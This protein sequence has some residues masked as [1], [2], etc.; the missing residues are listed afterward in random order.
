MTA[1]TAI[2]KP[3]LQARE[4]LEKNAYFLL[5]LLAGYA[6]IRSIVGAALRTFWFDELCTLAVAS[7]PNLRAV[8]DALASAVDAHPI[9]FYVAERAARGVTA[10][11]HIASR[12]PAILAFPCTLI[13]I[14]VY[15]KKRSGNLAALIASF[16]LL[17]T[18]LFEQ[19][20]R[21]A[22]AYSLVVACISLALVCYQRASAP[23]WRVL[24]ALSLMLAESFHHYSL[25]AFVPFGLA[26][27]V[28]F[29]R[30]HRFR[31]GVWL[32]IVLGPL[33][34]AFSWSLLLHVREHFGAHFFQHY[35][36]R[37]IAATYG[38]YFL[39]DSA[40][41]TA[42]VGLCFLA[43]IFLTLRQEREDWGETAK[44]RDLQL[45]EGTMV[46]GLLILPAIGWIMVTLMHAGM[47]DTYTISALLGVCLAVGMIVP[48]LRPLGVALFI[49]FLLLNVGFREFKFWES[50]RSL[51]LETPAPGLETFLRD[52]G[53]SDSQ[54]P[55]VVANGMIYVPFAYYV[56]DPLWHRLYY[57]T[58]EE[59]EIRYQ[60]AD[61][62]DRNVKLLNQYMPMQL[63]DFS[64]FAS[65][66]PVFLM[67]G[68]D[69]GYG[70]TWLA[71]YLS[72]EKYSVMA[73]GVD[74]TRRLFLVNMKKAA[75]GE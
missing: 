65:T 55:I 37:A 27:A 20:A 47:R 4:W 33:P 29:F 61:T 34:L 11:E 46:L 22:R 19:Y 40:Y 49:V 25:F 38:A 35:G 23:V 54:L 14:F 66:H 36:F 63:Q 42:I 69:P 18:V 7:R 48:Y 9:G 15:V 45:A 31:W 30:T 24:L 8:W 43:T 68:E 21:E 74:P 58:D 53:Y 67:Y 1:Q 39:T 13:C 51:H 17:S 41:G 50:A 70:N 59:K 26:E 12:L 72:H 32:A 60:G 73:V 57:L 64:E 56:H 3:L 44:P 6:L 75:A 62:F 28:V 71:E 5:A 52:S 16:L 2:D 10:N